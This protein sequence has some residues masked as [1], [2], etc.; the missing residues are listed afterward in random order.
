MAKTDT[1][2]VVCYHKENEKGYTPV[3]T[4]ETAADMAQ[5]L[6]RHGF[7][8]SITCVFDSNVYETHPNFK[9]KG[10]DMTYPRQAAL[11]IHHTEDDRQIKRVTFQTEEERNNF[12]LDM[13]TNQYLIEDDE[14]AIER[15]LDFDATPADDRSIFELM[16]EMNQLAADIFEP[17]KS[18]ADFLKE[19]TEKKN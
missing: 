9:P 19:E 14:V 5:E 2:W 15:A 3:A 8:A 17:G 11:I 16:G 6:E 12:V 1:P 7:D 4:P 13:P 10:K 18:T